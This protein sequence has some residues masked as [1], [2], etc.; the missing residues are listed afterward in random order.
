MTKKYIAK[1]HVSL[2]I[3]YDNGAA[4]HVSFNQ[5]TGGGSIYYSSCE[6]EQKALE[7]HCKYGRLF[8]LDPSFGSQPSVVA[9]VAAPAASP[10][11]AA[12]SGNVPG[13]VRQV[14]VASLPDAKEYLANNC[15][16]SRSKLRSAAAI[17]E[18]AAANNIEFIGI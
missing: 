5:L 2:T 7:N 4:K 9:P 16:V 15:G 18:A 3:Y 12:V 11:A 1:T 6:A 14:T 17:H 10:S 13:A 8:K